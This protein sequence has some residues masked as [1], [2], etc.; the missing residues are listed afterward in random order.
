MTAVTEC[1]GAG[2]RV[3]LLRRIGSHRW[4]P[5]VWVRG[6]AHRESCRG[7]SEAFKVCGSTHGTLEKR[8][9]K[10]VP[11]ESREASGA[12]RAVGGELGREGVWTTV[13]HT[14]QNGP[15]SLCANHTQG[16]DF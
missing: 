1:E 11:A 15:I 14:C 6:R 10:P 13:E 16:G 9:N 2:L 5:E 12:G 7:R 8:Q 4:E 3:Q